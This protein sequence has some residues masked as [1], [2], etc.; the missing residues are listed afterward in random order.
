VERLL[1]WNLSRFEKYLANDFFNFNFAFTKVEAVHKAGG[2]TLCGFAS[3]VEAIFGFMGG[4]IHGVVRKSP[5]WQDFRSSW[6][7]S[8]FWSPTKEALSPLCG[9]K[10]GFISFK[11]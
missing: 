11:K 4:F 2:A 1:Q 10:V 7:W 5:F 9:F 8:Y 3:T 6:F